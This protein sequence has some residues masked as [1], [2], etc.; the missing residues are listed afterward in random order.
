MSGSQIRSIVDYSAALAARVQNLPM[1]NGGTAGVRSV[2]GCGQNLYADPLRPGQMIAPAPELPLESFMH[3]SDLPDAPNPTPLTQD[4][5]VLFEWSVPMRLYVPRG[6]LRAA[7]ATLLPFY[8]G[9]YAAFWP[10]RTLGGLCLLAYIRS[11]RIAADDDWAWL[12]MDLSALE[13]VS[14]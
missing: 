2:F 12:D 4:G 14:Y 8:N 7:R 3:V 6:D 13:E 11:F 1:P 10:D 5:T 9:Y